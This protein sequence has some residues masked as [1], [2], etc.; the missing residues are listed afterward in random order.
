MPALVCMC[1]SFYTEF[2]PILGQVLV[3]LRVSADFTQLLQGNHPQHSYYYYN[4]YS[5]CCY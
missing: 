1:V 4:S 3:L 5:Y 2:E